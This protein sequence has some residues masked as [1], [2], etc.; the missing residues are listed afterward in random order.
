MIDIPDIS[1]RTCDSCGIPILEGDLFYHCRT[2]IV[3]GKD[4]SLSELKY[5][6]QIIAQALADIATKEEQELL[7]DIY[8]EIILQLC[9]QCRSTL[10]QRIQSMVKSCK[11]CAQCLPQQKGEKKGKI[12]QFS[13]KK[14]PKDS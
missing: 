12:L 7:D 6:D 10:I 13:R 4:Q 3:A 9:P 8:Q 11:G 14:S 1:T 2:E 5:P